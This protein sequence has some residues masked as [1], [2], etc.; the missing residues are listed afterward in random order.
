MKTNIIIIGAGGH[1]KVLIDCLQKQ[2][3]VHVIGILDINPAWHNKETLG[4]K[5]LGGEEKLVEFPPGAVQLVN[6]IGSIDISLKRK[7]IYQKFK[8]SGYQFYSI[9]H[10]SACLG[11]G[12]QLGEG[13]Q[14]MAGSVIQPDCIIG[15][16]VIINTGATIDH[17]CHIEEHVHISPG[18]VIAGNVHI[19]KG[20]HIGLGSIVIQ[21]ITIESYSLVGAGGV[22]LSDVGKD[23]RVAGVPARSIKKIKEDLLDGEL[24]KHFN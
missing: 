20:C 16:N 9:I 10:P 11:A 5:V 3:N 18:A 24:E 7:M 4:V 12:L 8:K 6:A 13:V 2:E 21:G 1:S 17:D 19:G 22:V 15:N 23:E 14:I